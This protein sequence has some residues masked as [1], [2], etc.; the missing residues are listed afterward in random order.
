MSESELQA[1]DGASAATAPMV[2]SRQ[3]VLLFEAERIPMGKRTAREAA[4]ADAVEAACAAAAVPFVRC[5]V[6]APTGAQGYREDGADSEGDVRGLLASTLH[7][8]WR[9]T[10]VVHLAMRAGPRGLVLGWK[11]DMFAVAEP[12]DTADH[13]LAA[14][15]RLSRATPFVPFFYGQRNSP[16]ASSTEFGVTDARAYS[17][18]ADHEYYVMR[19]DAS[20]FYSCRRD[21]RLSSTVPSPCRSCLRE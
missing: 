3:G 4:A 17:D 2:G 5:D 18:E 11:S 8:H 7:T 14:Q 16:F 21:H 20:A 15:V 6:T 10:R 19:C 9:Q 1:S 13:F 12:S